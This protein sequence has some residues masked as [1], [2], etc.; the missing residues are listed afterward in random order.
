VTQAYQTLMA[1]H[2]KN[3]GNRGFAHLYRCVEDVFSV[4][5]EKSFKLCEARV[6]ILHLKVCNEFQLIIL[7]ADGS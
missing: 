1:A 3:R 4:C 2:N 5:F 6:L 7:E